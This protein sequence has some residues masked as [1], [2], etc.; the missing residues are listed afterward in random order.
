[1]SITTYKMITCDICGMVDYYQTSSGE[2]A[3]KTGEINAGWKYINKKDICKECYKKRV[4]N[5]V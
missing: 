2:V 3:R 4:N 1:M 5:E